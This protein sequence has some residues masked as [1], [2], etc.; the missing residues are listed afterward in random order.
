MVE[1]RTI[2]AGF[3]GI[4]LPH[5]GVKALI[6]M[7]NKLIVH[8]RC[9][10]AVGWFMKISYSLFLAEMGLSSQPLQ[11]S[12]ERHKYLVTH[13]WMKMFW[14]KVSMFGLKVVV[15]DLHLPYPREGDRFIMQMLID[16]GY[17]KDQLRILN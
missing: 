13:S 6:A 3:Y 1:S 5:L 11:E 9:N 14:E 17:P 15:T 10:T 2:D 16:I 12:Y 8:Y 4:G 7:L